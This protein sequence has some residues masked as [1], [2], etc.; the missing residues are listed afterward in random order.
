MK[1]R[2]KDLSACEKLSDVLELAIHDAKSIDPQLFQPIHSDWARKYKGEEVCQICLA[3]AVIAKHLYPSD[4][5]EDESFDVTP[6]DFVIDNKQ[7]LSALDD[8][9]EAQFGCAHAYY[10][11]WSHPDP[12]MRQDGIYVDIDM[13]AC[14][15]FEAAVLKLLPTALTHDNSAEFRDWPEFRRHLDWLEHEVLPALRHVEQG[16]VTP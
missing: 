10:Q 12:N 3:G 7:K 6:Y 5:A 4:I 16:G 14:D 8:L 2:I 9:R 1:Q 11:R 15:N 13:N